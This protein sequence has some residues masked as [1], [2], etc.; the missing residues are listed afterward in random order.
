M[1]LVLGGEGR[2]ELGEGDER[3]MLGALVDRV[4]G[5]AAWERVAAVRWKD[6]RKYKAGGHRSAEHRNVLGLALK[7]AELGADAIVFVRDEDG[8]THVEPAVEAGISEAAS[9]FAPMSLV[10]GVAV[11]TADAW[12][13]ALLGQSGTE[14]LRR[15]KEKLAAA[16]HATTRDR[17]ALIA[18]ADLDRLPTD[19]RSFRRWVERATETLVK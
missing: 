13:L 1:R 10:G 14:S 4:R 3:G 2:H 6:I 17:E 16:G 5:G 11:R 15:P 12:C 9:L 18:D 19:A 8:E 7:A